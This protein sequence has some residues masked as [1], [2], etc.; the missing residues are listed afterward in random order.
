[1]VFTLLVSAL[2]FR[3]RL[4]GREGFG[5]ALVVLSLVLIVLGGR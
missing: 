2:V 4:S 1:M 5:I 3:E